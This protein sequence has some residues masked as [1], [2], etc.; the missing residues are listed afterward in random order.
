MQNIR[1][2]Q[3][4]DANTKDHFGNSRNLVVVPSR[5]YRHITGSRYNMSNNSFNGEFDALLERLYVL[6][7]DIP[8]NL[9][10]DTEN[11]NKELGEIK[12][13]LRNK[14]EV[15]RRLGHY[16]G[17][18]IYERVSTL[19]VP[20][21]VIQEAILDTA[22]TIYY[23]IAFGRSQNVIVLG[24]FNEM[25]TTEIIRNSC[26]PHAED[27]NLVPFV[28]LPDIINPDRPM[29]AAGTANGLLTLGDPIEERYQDKTA[30]RQALGLAQKLRNATGHC[31]GG[32][33]GILDYLICSPHIEDSVIYEVISRCPIYSAG[34][35]NACRGCERII[36]HSIPGS[37][38]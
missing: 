30:F 25:Q 18:S 6:A 31:K 37:K 4:F 34:N 8:N 10:L 26:M 3:D 24:S 5:E 7:G 15:K 38:Y 23:P 11:K 22:A 17:R 32:S 13:V 2:H 12:D 28:Y 1:I 36:M 19:G 20:P 29:H 27:V 16:D 21:E 35:K 14:R 33:R 9:I